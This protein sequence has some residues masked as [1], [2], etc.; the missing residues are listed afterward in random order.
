MNGAKTRSYLPTMMVLVGFGPTYY[1]DAF[2]PDPMATLSGRPVTLLV[3]A[4]GALFTTWV[5]LFIVQ[6]ALVAR[7]KVQVHRRLGIAGGVLAASMIVV[8]TLTALQAT[9]RGSAPPGVDPRSFLMVPLTDM[10]LFAG[11]VAT[12]LR[13]RANREAHKRLMLLAYVSIVAAA[14]ARLPG[15]L[16]LGPL[17][18]FGVAFL[19]M[20]AGVLYDLVS[21]GRVHPAYIWGGAVLVASVP[22]RLAVSSTDAW[23]ALAQWTVRLM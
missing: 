5:L 9:A 12:A 17:A 20:F 19:F 7:H 22:L 8:G 1:F 14:A 16:A 4:H 10:L 2:G 23:K 6:T 13:L 11:F 3:H 15:M 18:F 21:R